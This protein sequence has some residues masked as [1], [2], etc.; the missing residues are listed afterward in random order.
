[1]KVRILSGNEM[2]AVKDLPQDEAENAISTGYAELYDPANDQAALDTKNASE[3]RFTPAPNTA[4][5]R[6][7]AARKMAPAKL[8]A[9]ARKKAAG[10]KTTGKA[11][12][13]K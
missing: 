10:K 13:K 12:R 6:K 3:R 8:A 2:G 11:R 9:A 1:M 4:A 7:R 5:A